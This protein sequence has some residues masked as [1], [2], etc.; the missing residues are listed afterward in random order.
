M[1]SITDVGMECTQCPW[2][3]TLGECDTDADWE[4][5]TDHDEGRLRCP[6]CG[7]L[8]SEV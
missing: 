6:C 2:R 7:S 1:Q 3:G 4:D 5:V 8:V